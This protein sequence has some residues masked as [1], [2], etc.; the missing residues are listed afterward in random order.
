[1]R[2]EN[3]LLLFADTFIEDADLY[4][5]LIEGAAVAT[6]GKIS[7]VA[8]LAEIARQIPKL[9]LVG[10]DQR[11]ESILELRALV[12]QRLPRLVWIYDGRT[13]WQVFDDRRLIG[14]SRIDPCS[15]VLKRD[16]M[17]DW[18]DTHFNPG[19]AV[20]IFG[21]DW[22]EVH[23][24]QRA[25]IRMKFR[26]DLRAP[27]CAPPYKTKLE[28]LD[29]AK[30]AG[31][32]PPRLYGMGFAHNNCGGFCV[33]AGNA[34]FKVL[35]REMPALYRWHENREAVLSAEI[36]GY[37]VLRSRKGGM[38]TP[39]TMRQFREQVE[40]GDKLEDSDLA[41]GCGCALE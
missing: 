33:K 2:V 37:T 18:R 8:D 21:I 40:A 17:N 36:G 6:G 15:E 7:D 38:S 9:E 29:E 34:A 28:L 24:L 35:L 11:R 25:Q 1:M 26:W 5:F 14:N 19:N 23:R 3:P 12:V 32:E 10:E 31:I 30:A 41:A 16:L 13:P 4:R 20:L 27:L 22:T 39:V